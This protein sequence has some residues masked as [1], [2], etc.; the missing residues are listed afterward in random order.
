LTTKKATSRK[1]TESPG[2]RL[3]RLRRGRGITQEDL[4]EM[5]GVSQ[6]VELILQLAQILGVPADD[7]LGLEPPTN[8]AGAVGNRRLARRLQQIEKL[9]RQGQQAILRTIDAFL[10]KEGR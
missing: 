6:P 5:L 9:P 10:T 2:E 7:L 1:P 3:A 4:A 8:S